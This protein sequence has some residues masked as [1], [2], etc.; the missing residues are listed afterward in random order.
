MKL[1]LCW[2]NGNQIET[3]PVE[4]ET[5]EQVLERHGVLNSELE[6]R[7]FHN[8]KEVPLYL[9]CYAISTQDKVKVIVYQKPVKVNR[10]RIVR[11]H[12][13]A[14]NRQ[15]KAQIMSQEAARMTDNFF[16]RVSMQRRAQYQFQDSLRKMEANEESL[17]STTETCIDYESK[18]SETALPKCYLPNVKRS[19]QLRKSNIIDN[20]VITKQPNGDASQV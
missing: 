1:L 20:I 19:E 8:C 18:I 16:N 7:L 10:V 14:F 6:T 11:N 4:Y 2:L 13:K 15:R 5:F 3:E 9:T 17:D 12:T